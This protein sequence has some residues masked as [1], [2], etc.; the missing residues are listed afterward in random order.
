MSHNIWNLAHPQRT[1]NLRLAPHGKEIFG[2]VIRHGKMNKTVTVRH[3]L[4]AYAIFRCVFQTTDWS[5]KSRCGC[6]EAE[7]S[8]PTMRKTFARVATKLSFEGAEKWRSISTTTCAT[9]SSL[10]ADRTLVA[11]PPRSMSKTLLTTMRSCAVTNLYLPT[12]RSPCPW[13]SE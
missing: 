5:T 11:N 12:S 7:T 2:T 9:S 13:L 10:L 1:G 3:R 6:N 8:W 4:K